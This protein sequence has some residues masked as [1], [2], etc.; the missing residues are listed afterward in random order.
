VDDESL[1]FLLDQLGGHK[2]N[3]CLIWTV[4]DDVHIVHTCDGCHN[5]TPDR[6]QFVMRHPNWGWW[7]ADTC[8]PPDDW[9]GPTEG[10]E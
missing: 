2:C 6:R 5:D 4:G 3:G 10:G 1:Q 8:M 9:P 7:H